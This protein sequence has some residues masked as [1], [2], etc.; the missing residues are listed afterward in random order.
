MSH[1]AERDE[2]ALRQFVEQM[3]RT[4]A[5]WG[6]PRMAG[7]VLMT[8]LS[9]DEPA[10]TAGELAERLGVSPAAISGAVRYLMQIKMIERQPVP[11]SR[12][13]IYRLVDDAWYEVS[14][15]E[16]TLLKSMSVAAQDGVKAA[17]GPQTPAGARL[18][19]MRDYFVYVQENLPVLLAG[20]A[21]LKRARASDVR[22]S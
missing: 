3:A 9:S 12:R 7:R 6:F 16:M 8:M 19:N 18:A 15:A 4:L 11:G 1:P 21:E 22:V 10:L 5:D 20:W 13:D 2:A 17:G 14:L